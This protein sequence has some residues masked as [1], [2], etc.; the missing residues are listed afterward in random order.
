MKKILALIC[1]L[2]LCLTGVASAET[3]VGSVVVEDEPIFDAQTGK[4]P[5]RS[6]ADLAKI[7]IVTELPEDSE[8][9]IILKDTEA[10]QEQIALLRDAQNVEEYFGRA[11]DA[12]GNAIDISSTLGTQILNV[13]EFMTVIVS[14]YKEEY[15]DIKVKLTFATP[16]EAG[17]KVLVACGRAN[18]WSVMAGAVMAQAGDAG[19][20]EV[21][22]PQN[23]MLDLQENDS[24]LAVVSKGE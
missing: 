19:S 1:V 6:T 12:D 21:T 7:D 10:S 14:G 2:A 18:S 20:I 4:I 5:S 9:S 13:N 11:V 24:F 3:I 15:G 23:V 8:L 22:F 17:E 16:Y